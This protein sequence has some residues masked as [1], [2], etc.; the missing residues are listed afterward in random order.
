[1]TKQ[2][3]GQYL[4]LFQD[5]NYHPHLIVDLGD[6]GLFRYSKIPQRNSLLPVRFYDKLEDYIEDLKVGGHKVFKSNLQ[7]IK[8][9]DIYFLS[10]ENG[11]IPKEEDLQYL[12]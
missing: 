9:L 1:M 3:T 8:C 5:N 6:E 4:S 2:Y 10:I 12:I 7:A 11:Y